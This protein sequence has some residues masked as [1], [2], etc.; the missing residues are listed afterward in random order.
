MKGSQLRILWDMCFIKSIHFVAIKPVT[1]VLMGLL[2]FAIVCPSS[3]SQGVDVW[4]QATLYRD[5]WGTPHVYAD[6]PFAMAYVFGYAQAEDHAVHIL[7]AYRMANGQLSAVL[8][9]TWAESD[10]FS[11]KMGHARLAAQALAVADPVTVAL[12]EGFATGINAWLVDN[13]SSLPAWTDGVR[14]Q[15]VLA[16]WHAFLMSMAPF[17]LPDTYHRT[18]AMASANAWATAAERSTEGRPTLVMNPHQNHNGYFQWYEAHLVMGDMNIYGTTLRG[19]PVILQGHNAVMGWALTPN[20]PDFADMFIEE[21][22]APPQNPRDPRFDAQEIAPENAMLLHYMSNSLPYHI[23][24]NAGFETR[25]I[26]AFISDRGPIFENT[27][28]GLNS[29]YIGGFTDFGGLRQMLEMARASNL[30]SFWAALSLHQIPCFNIVYADRDNNIFYLYNTKAGLRVSPAANA[31]QNPNDPTLTQDWSIPAASGLSAIAWRDVFP[32]ANL[33]SILNPASGYVQACGNP[34][35]TVTEPSPL[36]PSLWPGWLFFDQNTYRAARVRQLLGKGQRSF[37]DH[38]SMLF[39]VVVPAALDM[40]PAILNASQNRKDLVANAHPDFWKGIELLQNWNYIAETNSAGMTFYHLWWKF[41]HARAAQHFPTEFAFYEA[42][43]NGVPGAQDIMLRSVE[44]AANALR[45]DYGELQV[46]W[47]ELHR[48]RH[49]K[50]DVALPGGQSGEPIFLASDYAFDRGKIVANYGYGFAM[51]TSFGESPESVSLLPFGASQNPASPHYADQ[52]TLMLER[53]FKRVR[54]DTDEV[55]RNSDRAV[56]KIIT[57]MP[58]GVSGMV[59]LHSATVIHARLQTDTETPAPLPRNTLPFSMYIS[60]ERTPLSAQVQIDLSIQI[61]AALCNDT[62]F[63]DLLL[64]RMEPGLSWHPVAVQN[65]DVKTRI[66]HAH[67]P[68][69]ARWYVVLGPADAANADMP[70]SSAAILEAH[71]QETRSVGLD[72]LFMQ[73][74]SQPSLSSEGSRRTFRMERLDDGANQPVESRNKPSEQEDFLSDIPGMHF[75][76]D[77]AKEPGDAM[78]ETEGE[79]DAENSV[80][81]RE[82]QSEPTTDANTASAVEPAD[83]VGIGNSVPSAPQGDAQTTEENMQRQR[84]RPPLPDVIPQDPAF[85]FGPA[86]PAKAEKPRE[87]QKGRVFHI[88]RVEPNTPQE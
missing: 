71:D 60:P 88:E 24:T 56:G 50:T 11:L 12:C 3:F 15:D 83:E 55:L 37:R 42:A 18:P 81:D 43:R 16:Y 30:A 33:P 17:E 77:A 62:A 1:F 2:F 13:A 52:M 20:W 9:E 28:H 73:H 32:L 27:S 74:D 75:G 78:K 51:A 39:D 57:L 82:D 44:E 79:L 6:N 40:V 36:D 22:E 86:S 59:T 69:P 76:P 61:P 23:R 35:W 47:G 54:F 41:A 64:Y 14:P 10:A 34:P 21:Y 84:E 29:W 25:Y 45:N 4:Q 46:P 68:I 87:D 8:G 7:L 66:I 48:I 80:E 58:L 63:H 53:R 67:D 85:V 26:P 31:Q 65:V 72:A 38:Q 70:T 19:L 5:E 49:G